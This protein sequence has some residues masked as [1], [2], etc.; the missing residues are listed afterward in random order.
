MKINM[1]HNNEALEDTLWETNIAMEN[2]PFSY[3]L[4]GKIG[5]FHGRTVSLPEGKSFLKLGDF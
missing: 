4:S 1:E 2:S 3:Y 5:I